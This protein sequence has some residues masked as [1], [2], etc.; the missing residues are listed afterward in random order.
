MFWRAIGPPMPAAL[1]IT[2]PVGRKEPLSCRRLSSGERTVRK[3]S[4]AIAVMSS[5][6]PVP[7]AAPT[8]PM[9]ST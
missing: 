2:F 1:A 4:I 5:A 8:T 6:R 9:S 3:Y 7:R